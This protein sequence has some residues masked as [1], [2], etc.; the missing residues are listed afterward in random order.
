MTDPFPTLRRRGFLALAGGLALAGCAGTQAT[1]SSAPRSGGRLRAAFAG[2]GAKEVLDPH[3]ASLFVEAARSKALYDKLADFGSDLTPV[4]RLA[5]K[6]EP[7]ADATTWRIT[8]RQASFHDGRPVR[9]ADVLSSYARILD[10]KKAFRA[11][12][13][14][15]MID[16]T[17]SRAVDDRTVEFVLTRPYVEFPNALA[18]FSAH[19]IPE[20]TEDFARPVGS[21]PFSFVS[22]TPG[23]STVLKRYADHWDGAARLDEVEFVLANEESARVNALLAGQVEYAHD[24]SPVTARAHESGGRVRIVR[25][26][27]SGIQAFAMKV[28]RPPFDNRDLREAMFLLADRP[29]LV[30]SVLSGSGQVAN[31]LYGK[32]YRHYAESI[33]QRERDL[34]KA[35]FLIKRAGAEGLKVALNTSEAATGFVEAATVFADQAK[36]AG[37]T[38]EVAVGDKDTFWADTLKN[39]S[40]SSF[41]SGAMPIESHVSQRLLSKSTTNVTK[42]ARPE[43][44]AL[45][46]KAVSTVDETARDGVYQEMQRTLHAE[47]GYLVWGFADWVVGTAQAV[48][49]VATAPANTLDWA[50]FDRVWLR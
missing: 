43:F 13:S 1:E 20:S 41:R 16:L 4:P 10:P 23:R 40:L 37:I 48:D 32:G 50:R 19:I 3:M 2:G 24:L 15:A 11:K 34:D 27:N 5:E 26:P 44:D 29:Q 9:A 36:Q 33:P 30:E 17:S 6:W 22:F 7:N 28:D 12:A 14:L 35:R 21:G 47:G 39:G 45:Y 38:I 25:S 8:L 42:W 31:D 49:G 46:D 18:T